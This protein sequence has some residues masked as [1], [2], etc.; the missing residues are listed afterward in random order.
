MKT[1]VEN[2]TNHSI[3]IF[4]DGDEIIMEDNRIVAPNFII[5]CNN[6]NDSVLYENIT[7][8]E[9]WL[10]RKYFFDGTTWELDPNFKSPEEYLA[11]ME[12]F[13]LEEEEAA[14]NA[15]PPEEEIEQ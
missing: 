12:A 3:F 7:V 4:D 14:L 11:E 1:I 15:V 9:D 13:R 10:G 8:P 5:A 6:K 2:S